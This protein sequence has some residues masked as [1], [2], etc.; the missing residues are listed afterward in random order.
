MEILLIEDE[1]AVISLIRR[2][3]TDFKCNISIALNGVAGLKMALIGNYDLILLDIMLPEMNGFEV[4]KEIR[5]TNQKVPILILSALDQTE[6][7]VEGFKNEADDYLTKP[8][9][10][11]EL[12]ARIGRFSRKIPFEELPV[13]KPTLMLLDLKLD[14]DSKIV[15]RGEKQITLTAT[16]FRLLELLLKNKNKVLTRVDILA[17]IWGI[18]FTMSTN[19]VDVYINYLRK[20]IDKD[21]SVKLLHTKVGMGYVLRIPYE[22]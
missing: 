2:G 5:K 10:I 6:D 7:I 9:N 22:N 18:N 17:D 19:V 1:T 12:K 3:L 16:E 15:W 13:K 21:F 8:F 4:C 11:Q 14:L 20:K